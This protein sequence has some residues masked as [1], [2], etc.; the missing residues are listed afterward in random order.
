MSLSLSLPPSLPPS[1]PLSLFSFDLVKKNS[2]EWKNNNEVK[3][4]H[5]QMYMYNVRII[6]NLIFSHLQKFKFL[7]QFLCENF[8]YK[9]FKN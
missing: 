6:A 9:F 5:I 3:Q 2:N 4:Q 8:E 7:I 1:L